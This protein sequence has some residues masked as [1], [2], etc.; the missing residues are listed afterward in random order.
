MRLKLFNIHIKVKALRSE[1][2]FALSHMWSIGIL[3]LLSVNF[4]DRNPLNS[5]CRVPLSRHRKATPHYRYYG[6]ASRSDGLLRNVLS[7]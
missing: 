3:Y 4:E 2:H 5:Q 1:I 7:C 6:A